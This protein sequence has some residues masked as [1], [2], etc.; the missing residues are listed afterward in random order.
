MR[1]SR[2][3][4]PPRRGCPSS[5]A[6]SSHTHARWSRDHP[7]FRNEVPAERFA[8]LPSATQPES[9]DPRLIRRGASLLKPPGTCSWCS[10]KKQLHWPGHPSL[11]A[12]LV[13][14][15]VVSL[16]GGDTHVL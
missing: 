3:L 15:C 8:D 4:T 6:E 10:G 12:Q 16:G 11:A 14:G 13:Q 2:G 9:G 7:R 1:D 5:S